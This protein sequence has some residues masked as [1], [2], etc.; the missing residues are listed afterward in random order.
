MTALSVDQP[1]IVL[2]MADDM[3]YECVR[4]NGGESY[5]TPHLDQMAATGVRF[6]HCYSQPICTPSRVQL[7]TGHYNHRN[8]VKFGVLDPDQTTFAH[9]LKEAGYATCVA[10]KWQLAGGFNAPQHFGFDEY[11]LWQL[12]IRKSRYPNPTIE[13]NGRVLPLVEGSYGPDIVTD[14]LVDFIDRHQNGPFLA[15]YPMILPHWPFEPTPDSTDWDPKAEGVL[16]GVGKKKYFPDMVTYTDKMVGKLV[17]KLDQLG[18]REN[19]LII[20]T[21]DNGT[22]NKVQSSL[23]GQAYMGGKGTMLDN[24]TH[25]PMIAN[26]TGRLAEGLVSSK[27]VDF[28]DILPTMVDVAGSKLPLDRPWDGQSLLADMMGQAQP[29]R[30]W[31]YC[32]YSRNAKPKE[33]QVAVR[34]QDYK[35]YQD[36]RFYNLQDDPWEKSPVSDYDAASAHARA[37]FNKVIEEKR[38]QWAFR[39]W[40]DAGGR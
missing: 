26:W 24:G 18:L 21:G 17:A 6:E 4:A 11:C 19:T 35:L 23:N 2:I 14:F 15:Y 5:H 13:Q 34:D 9:L 30:P 27:L 37:A 3:G 32:W 31:V 16:Q 8:Y 36:G 10:G 38:L 25:V 22:Y 1:N 20:F 40:G 29:E 33:L 39:N 7:M 12:T 28:S